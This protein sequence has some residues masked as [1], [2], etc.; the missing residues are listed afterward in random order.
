MSILSLPY[1]TK[2]KT[3]IFG[4]RRRV[5]NRIRAKVGK[6]EI[7]RSFDTAD[8]RAMKSRHAAFHAVVERTF[9]DANISDLWTVEGSIQP[10]RSHGS[11]APEPQGQRI[12][13][14]ESSA[15]GVPSAD[16][17]Q[18]RCPSRPQPTITQTLRL[19]LEDYGRGRDQQREDYVRY[20][21][22][23]HR[24]VADLIAKIG[25]KDITT[26]SRAD[27]RSFLT[28]LEDDGYSPGSIKKQVAFL[29]AMF[30]LG[31]R[32]GQTVFSASIDRCLSG[33]SC[34]L[35]HLGLAQCENRHA[36]RA[37]CNRPHQH[38]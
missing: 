37:G 10:I 27:A 4:Y 36:C 11:P 21:R 31:S 15:V 3:G 18:Q 20:A 22:E 35:L 24:M 16:A 9:S 26:V 1:L 34:E 14:E 6:T 28:H 30:G 32:M 33:W 5:P 13:D 38:T 17:K 25:D 19:K 23:R 29:N 8:L 7:V 12:S 2:T